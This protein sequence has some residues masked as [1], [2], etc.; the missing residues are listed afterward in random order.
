M[1]YAGITVLTLYL[2]VYALYLTAKIHITDVFSHLEGKPTEVIAYDFRYNTIQFSKDCGIT[3]VFDCE[4][5]RFFE[6][7]VA[8]I[9]KNKQMCWNLWGDSRFALKIRRKFIPAEHLD[10]LN[11]KLKYY[12]ERSK[13]K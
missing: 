9:G 4:V 7:K 6:G 1:L 13:S 11:Q 10:L 5:K 12:E 3:F 8:Q 2:L